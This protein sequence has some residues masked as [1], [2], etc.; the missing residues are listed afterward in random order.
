MLRSLLLDQTP[1]HSCHAKQSQT[2]DNWVWSMYIYI[3]IHTY[4]YLSIYVSMDREFICSAPRK[5][6]GSS[7]S[8]NPNSQMAFKGEFSKATLDV[9][10]VACVISSWNFFF[11]VGGVMVFL[12]PINLRSTYWWSAHS[13][14]PSPSVGFCVCRT[15][16][17]HGSR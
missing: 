5:E 7:C 16:Q 11:L 17:V 3:C 15:T 14:L 2:T 9:R 10:V 1:V 6:N 4:L 8:N 12:A 13:Q